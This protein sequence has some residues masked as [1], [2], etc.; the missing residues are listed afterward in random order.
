MVMMMM[1]MMMMMIEQ[2][3]KEQVTPMKKMTM[4]LQQATKRLLHNAQ[5]NKGEIMMRIGTIAQ[6]QQH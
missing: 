6:G 3:R 1:M 4:Q 2:I 5:R